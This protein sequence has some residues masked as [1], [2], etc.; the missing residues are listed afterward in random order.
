MDASQQ[1]KSPSRTVAEAHRQGRQRDQGYRGH[2]FGEA[3]TVP[4]AKFNDDNDAE[5]SVD[6]HG[7][8]CHHRASNATLWNIVACIIGNWTTVSRLCDMRRNAEDYCGVL[9]LFPK[10]GRRLSDC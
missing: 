4:T 3:G 9:S 1:M 5:H 6:L 8:R 10:P 7:R 2:S